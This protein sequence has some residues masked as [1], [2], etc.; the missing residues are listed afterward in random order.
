MKLEKG[1]V[2]NLEWR[3]ADCDGGHCV[4][5]A[6]EHGFVLARNSQLPL[7]V[8]RFTPTEWNAFVAGVKLGEFDLVEVA[9]ND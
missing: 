5:V 6:T 3:K 2:A 1:R 4:E 9:S 7:E 8:L